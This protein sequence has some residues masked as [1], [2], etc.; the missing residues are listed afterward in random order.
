MNAIRTRIRGALSA[1]GRGFVLSLAGLAG[2][3]TLFVWAVLSIAFIPL[4]VGLFTTPHVLELVRKHANRRRLLAVTWS[5]IRIPV[6]YRPFPKDLRTGFTGQVE[7]TTLMLKDPATW[8]DLR[9]LL[10]DMTAGYVVASLATVLMIYPLEGFVL[11]AGLWRVFTDDRYW[12]GFVPVDSQASGLAAAALGLAILAT[13]VLVGD[14]LVRLHFVITQAMLA[15]TQEQELARRVDRLTETRHEAVDTAASELRRIERDLHDG[16]QARLVA[17]GMNLGTVEAL[18]EKDPAQAKKLLAMARESS[19]EALTELRDLVRGIHPPVLAERGL[20]DAV[21]A[22]ALR[23]PI[24]SEVRVELDGRA[25]AAVE[26]AAYF[27]VSETLTNAAKHS[28]ADRVW[29]DVHHADAMLRVSV[30]DNGRGGAAV[31]SGSGLSGIERRLGTFDGI[32][33]VSSPAGG[34]TMVTMEIP[35]ELS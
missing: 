17:M 5:G 34:P 26:S 16:A 28:G 9:W 2:S 12:Y 35:C 29:V 6:P 4:G 13:G 31:G 7:R 32:M 24:E 19:A 18:I 3:L 15:P 8:R 21:R 25:D 11:A 14:R 27:A 10:V 30:T 33:A 1:A 23:L 20:G 22:L